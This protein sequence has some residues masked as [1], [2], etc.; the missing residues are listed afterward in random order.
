[1]MNSST[2]VLEEILTKGK[3][4]GDNSGIGF[5]G[6]HNMQRVAAPVTLTYGSTHRTQNRGVWR[7]HYCGNRG[8]IAPYCYRLY[9]KGKRKYS[10]HKT[11][12]VNKEAVVSQVPY[13]SLKATARFGWYFDSGCSRHMACSRD[14]LTNLEVHQGEHVTFG[15]GAKGKL[16]VIDQERK[17]EKEE[18]DEE[19]GTT[20]SDTQ[21]KH[22]ATSESTAVNET[23]PEPAARI[24]K[25]HPVDNII[26]QL[27]GGITTRRKER[28]DYRNMSGFAFL[29]GIIEEEIYV[30]QPKGF[31]D[32]DHP[33]NVYK[34]K[35]ALYGLKHAPRAWYER[36]TK[37]LIEDGYSQGGVNNT[38]FF[39]R[40]KAQIMIAQIY[41]DDIVFGGMSDHQTK[42]CNTLSDR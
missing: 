33:E 18:T 37:F 1:M 12:W 7:C 19:G 30:E 26:G 13:T 41:V 2:N 22:A 10:I 39:K 3:I 40:E 25:D 27:N 36:H 31:V 11:Q 24:Q 6:D 32:A 9:G 20:A 15:N 42:W 16:L 28:V 4:H 23:S 29:N 38:L 21:T 5:T 14:C 17:I 8:H 35:K 34:L